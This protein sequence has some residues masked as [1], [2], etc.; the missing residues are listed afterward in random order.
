[1]FTRRSVCSD[2]GRRVERGDNDLT[3][4]G[5]LLARG[6]LPPSCSGICLVLMRGDGAYK[7]M[8]A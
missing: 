2:R 6:E 1:M 7:M 4:L 5:D 8:N 3:S